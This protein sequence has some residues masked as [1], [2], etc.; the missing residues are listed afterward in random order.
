MD[1]AL[2]TGVLVE[3]GI[4][5]VVHRGSVAQ[6]LIERCL[7]VETC[8]QTERKVAVEAGDDGQAGAR[9]ED[10]FAVKVPMGEADTI[11]ERIE[12]R[13]RVVVALEVPCVLQVS[14][15][16]FGVELVLCP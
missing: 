8:G 4:G 2:R 11:V 16:P 13:H 6:L 3:C 15:K 9:R 5:D 10:A 7:I 12:G 14:F 1:G